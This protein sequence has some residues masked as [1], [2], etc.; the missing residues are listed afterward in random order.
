M[1]IIDD[2]AAGSAPV[3]DI[4]MT[5][6]VAPPDNVERRSTIVHQQTHDSAG[7]AASTPKYD[8]DS[9][10]PHS[11]APVGHKNDQA[12]NSD[13]RRPPWDRRQSTWERR[14]S[15]DKR[16]PPFWRQ[17]SPQGRAASSR[18]RRASSPHGQATFKLYHPRTDARH[19]HLTAVQRLLGI[20]GLTVEL[21]LRGTARHLL[22]AVLR[23]P[24]IAGLHHLVTVLVT[25]VH[26]HTAVL[27]HLRTVGHHLTAV[28]RLPGTARHNHVRTVLQFPGILARMSNTF[29]KLLTTHHRGSGT[30]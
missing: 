12:V 29:R 2:A 28:L 5:E 30:R 14:P 7:V 10:L 24:G 8:R 22:T 20:A 1:K 27:H 19:H 3:P 18:D 13:H 15:S 9:R 6:V 11:S 25:A 4:E 23:L 26:H 17:T 21:Q 16:P